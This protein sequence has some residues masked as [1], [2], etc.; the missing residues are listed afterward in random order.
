MARP[1]KNRNVF[2]PPSFSNF[3]PV[4]VRINNIEQLLLSLDEYEAL[5]LADYDSLE[6]SEAAEKMK[7]SRP[8]FTRLITKARQKIA[9]FLVEG[10]ALQIEGGAVHFSQNMIICLDCETR[11]PAALNRKD[12]KCPECGSAHHENLAKNFGHGRC[13]GRFRNEIRK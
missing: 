13:C 3:K 12:Y 5:R 1:E 8:T 4:G 10:K 2:A 6:H 7:I 9:E 11:Y